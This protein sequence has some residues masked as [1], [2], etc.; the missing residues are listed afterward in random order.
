V[1]RSVDDGIA[2]SIANRFVRGVQ[3]QSFRR[4]AACE[5][6]FANDYFARSRGHGQHSDQTTHRPTADYANS[7]AE[8]NVGAT[9]GSHGDRQRLYECA[10]GEIDFERK[11][12]HGRFWDQHLRT[13]RSRDINP[14]EA[15]VIAQMWDASTTVG[16]SPT[17]HQRIDEDRGSCWKLRKRIVQRANELMPWHQAEG[18]AGMLS[19]ENVEIRSAQP[20]VGNID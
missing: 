18:S 14:D 12:Q 4:A 6:D 11:G 16:T 5:G 1:S 13:Q 9:D 15:Q 20:G 3:A 17:G 7:A 10:L 2:R 19:P 8:A